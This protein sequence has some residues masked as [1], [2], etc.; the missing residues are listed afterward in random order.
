MTDSKLNGG[1]NERTK[2]QTEAVTEIIGKTV[3]RTDGQK[4]RQ[5]NI[6]TP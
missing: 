3:E 5:V 2:R 4:D 6:V 1:A